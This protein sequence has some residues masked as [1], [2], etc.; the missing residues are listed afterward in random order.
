VGAGI[1]F[2]LLAANPLQI[3]GL[4]LG[5]V[6]LKLVVLYVIA[7]IFRMKGPD[8]AHFAFSL[9]QGGEFA[10]V[11]ISFCLG[12]GLLLANHAAVLVAIVAISMAL[13][14]LLMIT[15]EKFIQPLFARGGQI[16]D[17]DVIDDSARVIIAGHGRFGMTVGRLLQAKGYKAVVLDHD[18][19]QIDALR[20]FGF[21]LFY[22][23]ASRP[24]LLE[25][26]GARTA[27]VLVIAIDEREKISEIV[28]TARTH[29]PHLRIFS[30][31]FDRVHA[32]E[33]INAGVED[34]YREVFS[35]S[36]DMAEQVL[37]ALGQSPSEAHRAARAF[38][39]FDERVMREQARHAGDSEKMVDIVRSSRAELSRVLAGDRSISP[40][41][42]D[43]VRVESKEDVKVP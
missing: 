34:V 40:L 37:V 39:N 3:I 24:D 13:A 32:Y 22:G 25:A 5:F 28:A 11:L 8:S 2:N 33:I 36:L 41:T 14:P 17:A 38:R 9:A 4:V 16:R 19:E 20:R 30:R 23:D 31:A 35:S 27:E 1:D 21:K 12:L 7:R 42:G 18:A 29:F 15:N 10:F 43:E 26:A 6:I